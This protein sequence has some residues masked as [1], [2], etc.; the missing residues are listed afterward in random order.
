MNTRL[1]IGMGT[2][3]DFNTYL[4]INKIMPSKFWEMVGDNED[5]IIQK[6][7]RSKSDNDYKR[8]VEECV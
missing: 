4:Y 2:V 7:H 8:I 3:E 6:I 5:S 1:G